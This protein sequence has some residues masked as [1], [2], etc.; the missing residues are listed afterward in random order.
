LTLSST[1][2]T[3]LPLSLYCFNKNTLTLYGAQLEKLRV[4]SR[5]ELKG[6]YNN[7]NLPVLKKTMVGKK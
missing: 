2:F 6:V 1:Q 4:H 5:Y 7:A 3:N